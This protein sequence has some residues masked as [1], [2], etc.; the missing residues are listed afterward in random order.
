MMNQQMNFGQFPQQQMIQQ[1]PQPSVESDGFTNFSSVQSPSQLSQQQPTDQTKNDMQ[2]PS[3]MQQPQLENVESDGFANFSSAQQADQTQNN[4]QMPPQPSMAQPMQ[5]AA[6]VTTQGSVADNSES[7]Q[8]VN[9]EH[10]PP[11]LPN[12]L[13]NNAS[14][15]S[16]MPA[17]N[18]NAA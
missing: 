12:D 10:Q 2:I 9:T 6:T 4:V 15:H 13:E 11:S 1:P 3:Q 8:Q 17:L 7:E 5:D 16:E 18:P 14:E